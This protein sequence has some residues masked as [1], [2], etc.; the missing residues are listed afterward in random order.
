MTAVELRAVA[1]R[2]CRAYDGL[3]VARHGAARGRRHALGK[4]LECERLVA[5]RE[6]QVVRAATTK[7]PRYIRV[8]QTKLNQAKAKLGHWNV[9]LERA[10]AEV[11]E[12]AELMP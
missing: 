11:Q 4:V 5:H 7:S 10:T 6:L 9:R 2:L 1:P 12:L 3:V 8:R